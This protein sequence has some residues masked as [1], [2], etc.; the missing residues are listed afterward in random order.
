VYRIVL[1][2]L[3]EYGQELKAIQTQLA[4][5]ARQLEEVQQPG[6]RKG[7]VTR[8]VFPDEAESVTDAATRLLKALADKDRREFETGLQARIR[9]ECRGVSYACSR[10]REIGPTFT[11]LLVDQAIKF[12]ERRVADMPAGAVLEIQCADQE[13]YEEQLRE[14]VT[15][16]APAPLGPEPAPAPTVAVLAAPDDE[17]SGRLRAHVRRFFPS[18]PLQTAKT[19]DD[20]IILQEA[21]GI[22]PGALPHLIYGVPVPV[23][24]EAQPATNSHARADVSW[25]PAGAG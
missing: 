8:S 25:A 16:A 22:S 6:P 14:L 9:H 1:D 4:T 12:L 18:L 10:P 20:I 21:Q 19:P 13:A 17:S 2:N 5:Y 3:P 23:T 15:G 11:N 24:G 7:G